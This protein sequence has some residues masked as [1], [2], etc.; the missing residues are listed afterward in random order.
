MQWS[1]QALGVPLSDSDK[2][3]AYEKLELALDQ[4]EDDVVQASILI[5]DTNGPLLGGEDKAIRIVVQLRNQ[6]S[7]VVEDLDEHVDRVIERSTDRLGVLASQRA[8]ILG[9]SR[10][11]RSWWQWSDEA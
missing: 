1:I 3:Q 6:D 4:F 7:L 11:K 2:R 8:E 5:V 9:R 10:R